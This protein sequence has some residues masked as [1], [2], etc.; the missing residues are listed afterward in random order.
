MLK[1]LPSALAYPVRGYNGWVFVGAVLLY[2]IAYLFTAV[3]ANAGG[4]LTAAGCAAYVYLLLHLRNVVVSTIEGEDDVPAWPDPTDTERLRHSVVNLFFF[5]FFCVPALALLLFW[6][7]Y[8]RAGWVIAAVGFLYLP[9]GLL[10]ALMRDETDAVNPLFVGRAVATAPL[11]YLILLL[12][13]VLPTAAVVVTWR[14]FAESLIAPFT[15]IPVLLYTL[16]LL[17]RLIGLFY[18]NNRD[19]LAWE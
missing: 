14:T 10:T 2:A 12:V 5:L 11:D 3:L 8:T 1:E 4:L 13:M 18:R 17:A 15:V 16:L 7:G 9:I 19:L 6:L